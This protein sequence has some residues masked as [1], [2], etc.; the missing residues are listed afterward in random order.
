MRRR[1]NHLLDRKIG[2]TPTFLFFSLFYWL[3]C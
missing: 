2:D 1:K 3:G